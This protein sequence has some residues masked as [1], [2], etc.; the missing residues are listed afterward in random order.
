MNSVQPR[1]DGFDNKL[2]KP[3]WVTAPSPHATLHGFDDISACMSMAIAS[4][5]FD[6]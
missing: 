6:K 1:S 3:N 5:G 2:R 4:D